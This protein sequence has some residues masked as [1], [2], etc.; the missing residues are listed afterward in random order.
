MCYNSTCTR[1][2]SLP[3]G[4]N[5]SYNGNYNMSSLCTTAYGNV[6]IYGDQVIYCQPR[7]KSVLDVMRGYPTAVQCNVS[8]FLDP[9]NPTVPTNVQFGLAQCGYNQDPNFYCTM[10]IGDKVLSDL[11]DYQIKLVPGIAQ[12]CSVS[13]IGL[14]EGGCA[15]VIDESEISAHMKTDL[16]RDDFISLW[17]QVANNAPCVKN[18]ITRGYWGSSVKV[19]TTLISF[20]ALVF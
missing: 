1:L 4:T 6:G 11:I 20:V 8:L 19:M 3:I 18:T 13:S 17:P 16:L 12:K 5:V 7:P 14:L 2:F 15:R 10:W 9:M